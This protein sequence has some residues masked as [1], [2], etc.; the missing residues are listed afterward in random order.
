MRCT[1][2]LRISRVTKNVSIKWSATKISSWPNLRLVSCLVSS[3]IN[4]KVGIMSFK[5]NSSHS[6]WGTKMTWWLW[7]TT[8]RGTCL[9][10]SWIHA[11]SWWCLFLITTRTGRN[12]ISSSIKCTYTSRELFWTIRAVGASFKIFWKL[13]MRCLQDSTSK[14]IW[15]SKIS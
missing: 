14:L 13:M 8:A 7:R 6:K 12:L 11:R 4:G 9:L 5:K 1:R 2:M 15:P 10:W 3:S